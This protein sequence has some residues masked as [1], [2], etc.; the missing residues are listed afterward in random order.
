MTD[1]LY[2]KHVINLIF[3]VRLVKY[4]S[5]LLLFFTFE[6]S[7]FILPHEPWTRL[8]RG[9]YSCWNNICSNWHKQKPALNFPNY[10]FSLCVLWSGIGYTFI[11]SHRGNRCFI[12]CNT[13][14]IPLLFYLLSLFIL[15]DHFLLL[16]D[17]HD[18]HE[19]KCI[20]ISSPWEY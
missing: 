20:C 15:L 5:L 19:K 14:C 10:L 16:C 18:L 17:T 2:N 7:A 9:V 13:D 4:R 3:S 8:I 1:T 6:Y 12:T 11:L